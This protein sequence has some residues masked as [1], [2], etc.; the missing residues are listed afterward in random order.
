[1]P[2]VSEGEKLVGAAARLAPFL[3]HWRV[4]GEVFGSAY[5]PACRWSSEESCEWLPGG[6]FLVNRWD[7][8]VGERRL[9][10]MAVFGY[11]P[12]RGYF[13]RFYDSLGNA[14]EYRVSILGAAWTLTG[15]AQRAVYE[16]GA[17]TMEIRWDWRDSS[18]WHALCTLHARKGL[19]VGVSV[20]SA[21]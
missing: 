18:G 21:P 6:R 5:G 11:D 3:G 8:S 10:G 17:G 4:E 7:A 9:Q 16:F 20:A 1:M 2:A 13:A 12:N 14:P 19:G 15:D